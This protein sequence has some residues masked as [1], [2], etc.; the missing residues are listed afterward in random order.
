MFC[1]TP[2][3]VDDLLDSCIYGLVRKLPWSKLNKLCKLVHIKD[4]EEFIELDDDYVIYFFKEVK[5]GTLLCNNYDKPIKMR[6]TGVLE[7]PGGCRFKYENELTFT[8]KHFRDTMSIEAE[9]D[10]SV[11]NTDLSQVLS[12][13]AKPK[14]FNDSELWGNV[15]R[16]FEVLEEDIQDS[17]DLMRLMNFSPEGATMTLWT[18]IGTTVII[19]LVVVILFCLI[20]QPGAVIKCRKCCC[21]FCKRKQNDGEA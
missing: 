9:I 19:T 5:F 3:H 7:I 10:D 11:W 6:G 13:V 18:L 2:T 12:K 15:D 14:R 20:Y 1:R 16:D 8:R 4:P 21:C 17:F